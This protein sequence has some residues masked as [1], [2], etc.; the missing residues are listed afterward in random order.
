V[1]GLLNE[2]IPSTIQSVLET[3]KALMTDTLALPKDFPDYAGLMTEA[4]FSSEWC[5]P[6]RSGDGTPLGVYS[7]YFDR[8]RKPSYNEEGWLSVAGNLIGLVV[9]RAR[10]LERLQRMNEQ[11]VHSEKLSA[12]G[13][14]S[15]SL[16]HEFNN[17]IMGIRNVL[18][19][20]SRE[21]GLDDALRELAQLAV[22]ECSRVM[23]LTTR[24]R[25]FYRPSD[26]QPVKVDLASAIEDMILL[27]NNDFTARSIRIERNFDPDVPPVMVV[28][29]QI[30]Q[31]ILNLLQ[32]A[33]EA[34]PAGTGRVSITLQQE[35]D[36]V[37]LRIR[38]NGPGIDK[39]NLDQVF[40]PFFTTKTEDVKGTGLGLSV[41]YGIVKKHGGSIGFENLDPGGCEFF[42]LLPVDESPA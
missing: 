15:A 21:P 25:D 35:G 28:E 20:I 37:A 16:S 4:G 13:K 12:I 1:L 2:G 30:K 40:D 36:Q 10:S 18:E 26:G 31:V 17:P 3:G 33:G 7:W 19:Q 24:L 23:R 41:C 42:V 29:D 11:L 34:V 32:N 27:K 14:L 6:L 9:E 8:S 38:D 5:L 39:K 22:N